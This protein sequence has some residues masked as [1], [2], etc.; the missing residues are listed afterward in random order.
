MFP[1]PE[2]GLFCL[3]KTNSFPPSAPVLER[4]PY[5]QYFFVSPLLQPTRFSGLDFETFVS[6]RVSLIQR[7]PCLRGRRVQTAKIVFLARYHQLVMGGFFFGLFSIRD[8]ALTISE[9][10]V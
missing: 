2:A 1:L 7:I 9:P 6:F 3:N 10:D 4:T 5:L 8:V